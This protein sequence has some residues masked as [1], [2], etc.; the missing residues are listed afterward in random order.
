M[1]AL[2]RRSTSTVSS[3]DWGVFATVFFVARLAVVFLVMVFFV[4][5]FFVDLVAMDQTAA[6][7]SVPVPMISA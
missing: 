5:V 4:M 7:R 1:S 6:L 2:Q 3:L